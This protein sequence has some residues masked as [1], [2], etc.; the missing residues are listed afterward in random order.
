MSTPNM[1]LGVLSNASG[2]SNVTVLGPWSGNRISIELT[3]SVRDTLGGL[4]CVNTV[5]ENVY[6]AL[7]VENHQGNEVDWW[8]EQIADKWIK[9]HD[10]WRFGKWKEES[11]VIHKSGVKDKEY[12][13]IV[14]DKVIGGVQLEV[15]Y[16][17]NESAN[18]AFTGSHYVALKGNVPVN[19]SVALVVCTIRSIKQESNVQIVKE[20][21]KSM[22]KMDAETKEN[23]EFAK[24]SVNQGKDIKVA[25]IEFELHSNIFSL[26]PSQLFLAQF[27]AKAG[28]DRW[29]ISVIPNLV[30]ESNFSLLLAD[31]VLNCLANH[32]DFHISEWIHGN[33]IQ[34][35]DT[36]SQNVLFDE[37]FKFIL[38]QTSLKKALL[39]MNKVNKKAVAGTPYVNA[40]RVLQNSFLNALNQFCPDFSI[41]FQHSFGLLHGLNFLEPEAGTEIIFVDSSLKLDEMSKLIFSD[42]LSPFDKQ[43]LSDIQR[44]TGQNLPFRGVVALDT[45][46]L[47]S[48]HKTATAQRARKLIEKISLSMGVPPKLKQNEQPAVIMQISFGR[49]AFVLDLVLLGNHVNAFLLRL[50]KDESLLKLGIGFD[51]DLN[52]LRQTYPKFSCYETKIASFVDLQ[53]MF[54]R[55]YSEFPHTISLIGMSLIFLRAPLDKKCQLSNWTERPLTIH[56]MQYAAMDVLVLPLIFQKLLQSVENSNFNLRAQLISVITGEFVRQP[57]ESVPKMLNLAKLDLSE[58]VIILKNLPYSLDESRLEEILSYFGELKMATIHKRSSGESKG[59]AHVV[60][61]QELDAKTCVEKMDGAL[62]DGR[63]VHAYMLDRSKFIAPL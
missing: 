19:N 31:T 60:F 47:C 44:F 21:K 33:I 46:S 9:E 28:D 29:S 51:G 40:A 15:E 45:E 25:V 16:K 37:V 56:Q 5:M 38:K 42:Y 1:Y 8:I 59:T 13:D 27:L 20:I 48:F 35:V 4:S 34:S 24:K 7:G 10:S 32:V 50:F 61:V 6:A 57:R 39:L 58:S 3:G 23:G 12:M 41:Y 2:Q 49:Y 63:P 54:A 11:K 22:P 62:L 18:L 52:T 43:L 26:Y 14:Q 17:M 53:V 30:N 36:I 55:R